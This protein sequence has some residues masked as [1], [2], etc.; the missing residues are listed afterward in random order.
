M[1]FLKLT[2]KLLL[3]VLLI[4]TYVEGFVCEKNA[5]HCFTSL[6][7]DYGFTMIDSEIGL[8]YTENRKI[9]ALK[10][11]SIEVPLENVI[12][13]DGWNATQPLLT[14]NKSMPGPTIF[15]YENQTITIIVQ[16]NLVNEP[17]TIHWHGIDQLGWPAMDGVAF[18]TQCPILPGQSFNYTFQPRFSGTYWYHSHVGNQRDMGLFGAFIVRKKEDVP[19]EQQH[20]IQLQEWNHLYGA[21]TLL[22][23]DLNG[24]NTS[25]S[26]S[27][28][29]NGK[30][31]FGDNMAPLETYTVDINAKDLF[32]MI[33]VGSASTFLFSIPGISLIVKETDGYPFRETIVDEIIIYPAERYDFE[34]DLRNIQPG[35]YNM[36]VHI[37]ERTK[38]EKGGKVL[39]RAFLNVTNLQSTTVESSGTTEKNTTVLNCPFDVY[40]NSPYTKCIPV[41]HLKSNEDSLSFKFGILSRSQESSTYFLN[42]GFPRPKGYSSINGR[43]FIWP[44]VSALSQPSELDTSCSNCDSETSCECTHSLTL[45]TG[46]E[47]IMVLTNVGNGSFISHPIH[48]HGHT[49]EVLKM[50]FPTVT[51]NGDIIQNNDILCSPRLHNKESQCNNATWRNSSWMD[52]RNIP[53]INLLDPVRKDTIVVPYGGYS[54][55][56][57]W[58]TN[59]GIWFMHCHIDGHMVGGMALMLNESFENIYQY[60]P[61]GLPTCHSFTNDPP[62]PQNAEQTSGSID[63]SDVSSAVIG[64]SVTS[65]LLFLVVVILVVILFRNRQTEGDGPSVVIGHEMSTRSE[66][67]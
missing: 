62:V 36:T 64:L 7:I 10:N 48:M 58:A 1:I 19:L 28:L 41:S 35:I 15:L 3:F 39:G 14:A 8:V 54:V 46:S 63:G 22:K 6:V 12:T 60:L 61:D 21:I 40:P 51:E 37:L 20:I 49:F 31:E 67:E 45:K 57:I 42:F 16:N 4:D 32:R 11:S 52:Y 13:A 33:N 55:I 38:L 5:S 30:G 27:I 59:P 23:A 17:V 43:R 29:I 65:V 66:L 47:I 2:Y 25:E 26:M 24:A 50:G 9:F 18:V 44:T 56:R 53:G 34:L